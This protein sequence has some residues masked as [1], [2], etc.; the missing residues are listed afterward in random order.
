[1]LTYGSIMDKLP[2][3][4]NGGFALYSLLS[5]NMFGFLFALVMM[6]ITL[7][8]RHLVSENVKLKAQEY[9][10][11]HVACTLAEQ[12][13][14]FRTDEQITNTIKK[15]QEEGWQKFLSRPSEPK[16]PAGSEGGA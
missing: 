16:K 9:V 5:G 8:V 11:R 3:A 4:M 14:C 2:L 12:L 15:A 7:F 13:H 6:V 10:T 1:M